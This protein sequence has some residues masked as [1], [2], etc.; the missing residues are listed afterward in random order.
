MVRLG[1]GDTA[2]AREL[3][4]DRVTIWRERTR[5]R[6]PN[7]SGYQAASAQLKT[8]QRRKEA[9]ANSH[10]ITSYS[11][12]ERYCEL[13][14]RRGYSP[15]QIAGRFKF[16][17]GV[18]LVVHDTIYRWVY[19]V[20]P[21]LKRYLPRQGTKYR[22]KH[23]TKERSR[24]RELAKKRSIDERPTVVETRSRVGDW[25]GDS[26]VGAGRSGY[27]ATTT[28]RRS[29]YT[30]GRKMERPTGEDMLAAVTTSF[31]SIPA[32]KRLT[33]TLDNGREMSLHEAMEAAT[34][35]VIYFAHP[36][37]SWERGTS[38]NTN[39]LYRRFFPKKMPFDQLT[40]P[41]VDRVVWL[42]NTRPRKRLGYMSPHTVFYA[43]VAS[44]TGI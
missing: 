2:I 20:R 24:I 4:K 9:K 16:V 18:S 31:T 41:E 3:G 44:Q 12:L 27:L 14:L 8:R 38:E 1:Y 33:M 29:G 30:L 34:G 15:E 22:H 23:G 43:R 21:D 13:A 36:Y 17:L 25:E 11:R 28:D 40:Q 5:N 37:H 32:G 6:T 19:L 26:I 35:L 42:L 10:K 7:K 39:G